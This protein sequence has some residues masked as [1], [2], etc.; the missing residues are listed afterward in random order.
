MLWLCIRL[1]ALQHE[2]LAASE[3]AAI[4][5]LAAWAYQWSSLVSYRLRNDADAAHGG[6]DAP[7]LWLE[8][9]ASSALFGGHA[10]LLAK[11]E[12]DLTQ[13]GY[14]YTCALTPSPTGSA[15]LTRAGGQ[16]CAF[17]RAQLPLSLL[18]LPSAILTALQSAGLRCIEEVLALPADCNAVR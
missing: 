13:L 15:L 10:A 6:A 17:T 5:R 8:F 1:P 9:G 3:H 16:C 18:E 12:T 14:S 7:L 11:I 2:A 4:E